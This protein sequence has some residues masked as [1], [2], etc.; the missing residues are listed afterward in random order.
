MTD[1]A[2]ATARGVISGTARAATVRIR[3]YWALI[4]SLQTGLLLI[5]A[6]AGYMSSRPQPHAWAPLLALTGSLFLSIGGSTALNMVWDRDID[7][8][9]TRTQ[10]RPLPSQQLST[11]EALTIGIVM[12]LLGT[13]WALHLSIAYG[14]VVLAGVLFDVLVYTCWLKR[15]TPWSI[16]WGGAAGAMPIV[17]GRVLGLGTFDAAGIWL[18]LA[19]LL[20]IPTHIMT[21]SIQ[22]AGQYAAAGVPVFP[23]RYSART[24]RIIIGVSTLGAVIAMLWAMYGLDLNGSLMWA[25][26]GLGG[27]LCAATLVAM[28]H[29]TPRL[30]NVLYKLASVYMLGSMIILIAAA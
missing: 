14:V 15:R 4:K 20:W 5:T 13:A 29:A 28:V 10:S 9:M 3:V 21:F 30:N 25:A 18:G 2:L 1:E 11:R 22:H 19:I 23:N 17:A 27:G 16:I 12:V 8:K 26:R 6:I 24:T 7:T